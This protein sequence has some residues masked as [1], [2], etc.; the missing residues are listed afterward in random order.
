MSSIMSSRAAD[1]ARRL[2]R[3]AE[4]V[5]RHYLP[6][7][8]RHGR[9]W[10]VGDVRDTPGRSLYVRLTGPESGPGAAGKWTDA[11]TGEHGDL[12]DLIAL[13]R[14][15]DALRDVLDEAR[16][17]LCLPRFEPLHPTREPPV[18]GGSPDAA[19]RLFR[20][21]KSLAGTQ[22]EA[23][24]RAR[25]I[26]ARL[27]WPSLR[28]HPALWY[29]A[30]RNAIRESWPGLLAAV[31][32][33]AG[34]ITG[35]HRTWLDRL[36]PEKAPL[37]DPRRAL[38]HLLGN[39]V[40]FGRAADVLVAGEGIETMLALKSVLPELPMIAALSAN[41]LAALDLS[42]MLARLYVARDRDA[43]GRLA[44]ERLHARGRDAGIEVR[45]L[46]PARSD[47]NVDLRRLGPDA[48]LARLAD[49]LIPA[50]VL[51]FVRRLDAA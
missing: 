6:N 28:F 49:Q 46:M 45:D 17:F 30:D 19:R 42:P 48:M 13:N 31:T 3:D 44:A 34:R 50:D 20:A 26:T 25:G 32:D 35:V 33:A 8:R 18:P 12:L 22:A 1:L 27:D 16:R 7:G 37:A 15:L 47:F 24:L 4:S 10:L 38:G 39:G 23:Y 41:H 21:G 5:C 36:R 11:A 29:R 2:A 14:G 51:R 43:A 9:Y 40:R